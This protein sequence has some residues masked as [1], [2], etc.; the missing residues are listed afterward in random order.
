MKPVIILV[1]DVDAPARERE[2]MNRFKRIPQR[3]GAACCVKCRYNVLGQR[4]VIKNK[5]S[6]S[7]LLEI[8]RGLLNFFGQNRLK[9]GQKTSDDMKGIL[10]AGPFRYF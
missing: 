10:L 4:I 5:P 9:R 6:S 2:V 7:C 8:L 1:V 3:A